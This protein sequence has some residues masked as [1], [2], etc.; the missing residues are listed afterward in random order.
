MFKHILYLRSEK[1]K[2]YKLKIISS[3]VR[4]GRKGPIIAQWITELAKGHS[5]FEVELLD[6]GEIKLPLMD[7]AIHPVMRQYEHDYT[8]QWS[9]K[10]EEA[11]AFIWNTWYMSGPTN[12][13]ALLVIPPVLLQALGQ[14]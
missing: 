11:D 9:A 10:I 12:Q 6:L 7:E 1:R 5:N 2:M 8:R 4:P 3:T 14:L 13:R